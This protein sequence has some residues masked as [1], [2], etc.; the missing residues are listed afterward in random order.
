MHPEDESSTMV[1]H[2]NSG[3]EMHMAPCC[4]SLETCIPIRIHFQK[5]AGCGVAVVGNQALHFAK[6]LHGIPASGSLQWR[7]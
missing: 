5:R 1:I 3:R 4:A 2:C 7:L 6:G